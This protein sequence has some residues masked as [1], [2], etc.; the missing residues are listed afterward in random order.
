MLKVVYDEGS[1][2]VILQFLKRYLDMLEQHAEV[3][4]RSL[5]QRGS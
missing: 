3:S 4:S 1:F 5:G 2:E